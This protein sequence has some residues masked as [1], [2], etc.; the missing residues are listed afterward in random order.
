L[1]VAQSYGDASASLLDRKMTL[2]KYCLANWPVM[3]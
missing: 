2:S 3:T 1:L